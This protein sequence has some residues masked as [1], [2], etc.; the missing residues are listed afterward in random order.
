MKDRQLGEV[1]AYGN[2]ALGQNAINERAKTG[3]DTSEILEGLLQPVEV[4]QPDPIYT[5]KGFTYTP[6][7]NQVVVAPGS[8]GL[9]SLMGNRAFKSII[10]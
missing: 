2:P 10:K 4:K 1:S 8:Q 6:Y 7:S 3:G 9:A 5:P